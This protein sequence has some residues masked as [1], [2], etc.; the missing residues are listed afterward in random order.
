MKCIIINIIIKIRPADLNSNH[1]IDTNRPES[2][3]LPNQLKRNYWFSTSDTSRSSLS[4]T[5][6]M[7]WIK[8][9]LFF[10]TQPHPEDWKPSIAPAGFGGV[11]KVTRADVRYNWRREALRAFDKT[12]EMTGKHGC[13]LIFHF[14]PHRA[15]TQT[16]TGRI[17]CFF[18]VWGLE[19]NVL[20]F[21]PSSFLKMMSTGSFS[22]SLHLSTHAPELLPRSAAV[23]QELLTKVGFLTALPPANTAGLP[24]RSTTRSWR[25][26]SQAVLGNHCSLVEDAS[27]AALLF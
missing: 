16:G 20:F 12:L 10:W 24:P 4:W 9:P 3:S 7:E 26:Y 14:L 2:I 19:V 21:P 25:L 27:T 13:M 15:V 1:W 18:F 17:F 5:A 6:L 11:G 8:T 23:A 22:P